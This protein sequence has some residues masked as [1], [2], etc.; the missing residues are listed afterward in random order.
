MY[1]IRKSLIRQ[2]LRLSIKYDNFK[3]NNNG[4]IDNISFDEKILNENI[5]LANYSKKD[6]NKTKI[7]HKISENN[8]LKIFDEYI[9]NT[10]DKKF[11][12]ILINIYSLLPNLFKEDDQIIYHNFNV[13]NCIDIKNEFKAPRY[14]N[15]NKINN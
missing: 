3:Y 15:F 6:L 5:N 14:I 7:L 9:E 11:K 2:S 13:L 4:D 8:L 10:K 1:K 12:F